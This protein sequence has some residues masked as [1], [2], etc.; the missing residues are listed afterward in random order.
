MDVRAV[1]LVGREH[2][3]NI[4][5]ALLP[6][7]GK[8]VLERTLEMLEANGVGAVTVVAPQ[9]S[10][11]MLP[12]GLNV[13]TSKMTEDWEAAESAFSAQVE[14]G[15]ELVVFLRLG[16]YAEVDWKELIECHARQSATRVTRVWHREWPL[17]MF[18]VNASRRN[19]GVTL[20]RSQMQRSRSDCTRFA[21]AHYVNLLRD[22]RD[23]RQLTED[24][25]YQRCQLRPAGLEVRP[26][27]W[28]GE[29]SRV[30]RGARLVAPVF[31]GQRVRVHAGAVVTRGSAIEHHSIVDCGTVVEHSTVLP[32]SRLGVGLDFAN[33]IID[34]TRLVQLKRNTEVVIAD[35][36]LLAEVSA[37]PLRRAVG[38]LGTLLR[39]TQAMVMGRKEEPALTTSNE[40]T[41]T[42]A[43]QYGAIH[44]AESDERAKL[45]NLADFA[46]ARRY[47]NQ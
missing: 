17:D 28:M 35:R 15:A 47:G 4:P 6:V 41:Q 45:P 8:S 26:G 25:L 9:S 19:E 34:R 44:L 27:I 24:A 12:A 16:C 31:V 43:R 30:E 5:M 11:A 36:S 13:V 37:S 42:A 22:A 29:N 3:G 38:G 20:L 33:T 32:Y 46:V 2:L 7:L 10:A 40:I 21:G 39:Q 23:L 1:V 14:A 18:L